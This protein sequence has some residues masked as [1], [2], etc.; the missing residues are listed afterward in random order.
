MSLQ[1]TLPMITRPE[2]ADRLRNAVDAMDDTI[3]DIRAT[4]FAL[5]AR[6]RVTDRSLRAEILA[7]VDEMTAMLGFAPT[8]RLGSGLDSRG[9]RRALRAAARR[10]A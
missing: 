2:V 4:I 1:G 7:L 6:G 10:A 3:K 5:Q 8:L 9:H